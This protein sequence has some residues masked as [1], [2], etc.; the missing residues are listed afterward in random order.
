M[1]SVLWLSCFQ[2]EST[3]RYHDHASPIAL[4]TSDDHYNAGTK[5]T[6]T[7][8]GVWDTDISNYLREVDVLL[9]SKS[10]CLKL[11]DYKLVTDRMICAGYVGEGGRDACSVSDDSKA[12]RNKME[13][14]K[15]QFKEGLC[16]KS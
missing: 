3:I 14:W 11:F 15:K 1:S 10:L 2:L 6:V 9:V 8:W 7:G 12:I 16:I 13:K 5:A 4:A